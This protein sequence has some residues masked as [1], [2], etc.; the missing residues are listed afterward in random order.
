ML[1]QD[2]PTKIPA[3]TENQA[4]IPKNGYILLMHLICGIHC[5][6]GKR[7]HLATDILFWVLHRTLNIF[8]FVTK[9]AV[10]AD[11]VDG[12]YSLPSRSILILPGTQK[13]RIGSVFVLRVLR[14]SMRVFRMFPVRI[15]FVKT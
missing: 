5:G 10:G 11:L 4:V 9:D 1:F 7:F 12:L 2:H 15:V 3:D 8:K 13:F 14:I 6:G